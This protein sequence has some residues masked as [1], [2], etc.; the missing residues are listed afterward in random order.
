MACR[1]RSLFVGS[2]F[3]HHDNVASTRVYPR[4]RVGAGETQGRLDFSQHTVGTECPEGFV[5]IAVPTSF[6]ILPAAKGSPLSKR[7]VVGNSKQV[8]GAGQPVLRLEGLAFRE[9]CM[10]MST[11]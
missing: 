7:L 3:I 9:A 1:Y 4:L 11:E 5:S 6:R 2:R 8:Q 10:P